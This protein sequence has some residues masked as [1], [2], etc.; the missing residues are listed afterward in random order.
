MHE[1]IYYFMIH[2]VNIFSEKS[3]LLPLDSTAPS[4]LADHDFLPHVVQKTGQKQWVL[5]PWATLAA[6]ICGLRYGRRCT[7]MASDKTSDPSIQQYNVSHS[8]VIIHSRAI[9]FVTFKLF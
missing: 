4:I 2:G 6:S 5:F 1:L 3:T 8:D 7:A 9:V